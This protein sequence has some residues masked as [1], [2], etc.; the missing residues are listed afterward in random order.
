MVAINN[1]PAIKLYTKQGFKKE[2]IYMGKRLSSW[3][4]VRAQMHAHVDCRIFEF[5]ENPLDV[6]ISV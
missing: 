1:Q 2:Q 6:G 3:F 5:M 4:R